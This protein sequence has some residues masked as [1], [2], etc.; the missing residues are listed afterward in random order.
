[1]AYQTFYD[2]TCCGLRILAPAAGPGLPSRYPRPR[3]D[4]LRDEVLR[5][6]GDDGTGCYG[7]GYT[8]KVTRP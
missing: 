8:W 4:G 3:C 5:L 7:T 6:E 2:C 1:M